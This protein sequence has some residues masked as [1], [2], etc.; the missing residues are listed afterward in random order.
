[1]RSLR[2]AVLLTVASFQASMVASDTITSGTGSGST[3]VLFSI[4]GENSLDLGSRIWDS[5]VSL[6]ESVYFN[7]AA[8]LN[9]LAPGT[10]STPRPTNVSSTPAPAEEGLATWAILLIALGGAVLLGGLIV[11]IWAAV[12]SK[13]PLVPAHPTKGGKYSRLVGPLAE[14]PPPHACSKVIHVTLVSHQL[15]V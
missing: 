7:V 9:S 4:A 10:S 5:P 6:Y 12:K 2:A 1:M 13:T 15:P 8:L 14:Y 11:G 3:T